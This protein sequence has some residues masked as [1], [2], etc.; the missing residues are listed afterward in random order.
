MDGRRM[1]SFDDSVRVER[2]AEA[3]L[4]DIADHGFNS[5]VLCITESDLEQ[6][7][8]AVPNKPTVVH[9]QEM[10]RDKGLYVGVDFWNLGN[11]LGGEPASSI[12]RTVFHGG[13]FVHQK[14]NPFG[15]AFGARFEQG[16]DIAAAGRAKFL[17]LDE[18]TLAKRYGAQANVEFIDMCTQKAQEWGLR[19]DV[20]LTVNHLEKLGPMV[21]RLSGVDCLST[22][23]IYGGGE[24]FFSNEPGANNDSVDEYIGG[25]AQKVREIGSAAL[26]QTG[27]WVQLH[28]ITR[29]HERAIVYEGLQAASQEVNNVGA[30]RMHHSNMRPQEPEL[31]W[32]LA[33]DAMHTIA[34][35]PAA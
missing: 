28:S 21:A 29:G 4:Q 15:P 11:I 10:A 20:C 8:A 14:A 6:R 24:H 12:G 34:A 5:V 32:R 35:R 16:L 19:T 25:N 31:A 33:G 2:Y 13:T 27:C 23:P 22:D 26:K 1:V 3:E 7:A 30:W 9:M 17:F 18:P